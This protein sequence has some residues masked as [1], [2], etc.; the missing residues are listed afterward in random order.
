M[1]FVSRAR[2][3]LFFYFNEIFTFSFEKLSFVVKSIW[4]YLS[5]NCY[6]REDFFPPHIATVFLKECEGGE[7]NIP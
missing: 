5:W 6:C 4:R 1:K 2:S 3:E 7:K